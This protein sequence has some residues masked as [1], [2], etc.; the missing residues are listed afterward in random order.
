MPYRFHSFLMFYP[1]PPSDIYTNSFTDT[2]TVENLMV[3]FFMHLKSV[4]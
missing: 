2:C 1:T 3:S 4:W